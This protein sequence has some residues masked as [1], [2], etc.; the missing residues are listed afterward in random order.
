MIKDLTPIIAI[1]AIAGLEAAAI[2][3]GIDGAALA[4]SL[5]VIAGLG[6]YQV[7]VAKDRRRSGN[8]KE[9]K[10]NGD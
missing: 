7:K 1:I 6:G 3:S 2:M 9:A 5:A 10:L 4:A 8:N